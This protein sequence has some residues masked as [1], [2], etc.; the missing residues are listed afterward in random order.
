MNH[1]VSGCASYIALVAGAEI[2]IHQLHP[3]NL[4][5]S[6]DLVQCF[7]FHRENRPNTHTPHPIDP[8]T[9][10]VALIEWETPAGDRCT[11]VAVY[12]HVHDLHA[13]LILDLS[14]DSPIVI[15]Q[16][17][18]GVQALQWV[19]PRPHPS[20]VTGAYT[21]CTQICVFSTFG[22]EM[23]LYSLDCTHVLFTVPK[24]LHNRIFMRPSSSDLWSVVAAPYHEKNLAQRSILA[25]STSLAPVLVHFYNEGSVS[26][27]L[28][29]LTLDSVPAAEFDWSQSGKWL[30]CFDSALGKFNL[31]VLNLLA[32]HNLP[33]K[34]V[35]RHK[36][37][38]TASHTYSGVPITNCDWVCSWIAIN[39]S[40]YAVALTSDSDH[41]LTT[42]AYDIS[43]MAVSRTSSLLLDSE[44]VWMLTH[45]GSKPIYKRVFRNPSLS[46]NKWRVA[47]STGNHI[48][49]V[50]EHLAVLLVAKKDCPISFEVELLVLALLKF[51]TAQ[52]LSNGRL[53][54]VFSD[55]AAVQT[56]SGFEVLATS[57][58]LFTEAHITKKKDPGT[59][60]LTAL[61]IV[62]V[63]LVE[64]TASG[65]VWRQI[66]HH[67]ENEGIADDSNLEIMR[68][69]H[70][71]EESSKVVH[72]IHDV[73]HN[74]WGQ[75]KRA[76][77]EP[78][79]TFEAK[80][81]V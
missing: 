38:A 28:A 42:R 73:Q 65:P 50:T 23:R 67:L 6:Y 9:P 74:E 31:R 56:S 3:A 12:A 30:L 62:A 2:Q 5:R 53:L 35:T 77:Q 27:V 41:T 10:E 75:G 58:Y 43:H 29:A 22:L 17:P 63:S 20:P 79:D 44:P 80:R 45:T 72:L 76:L 4:L 18:L 60:F 16:D 37:Q 71:M 78:T 40:D 70:Y 26:K 13:V 39:G 14:Q 8:T 59:E 11:K 49:V 7:E 46:L 19:P 57:R 66:N 1:A 61:E 36:A 32:I 15:E 52:L 54:V 34:T 25:H 81:K 48:L 21:G 51:L 68:K 69:F 33:V 64:Q 47:F 24:P 55:H